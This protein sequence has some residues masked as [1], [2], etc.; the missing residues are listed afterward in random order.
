MA[1]SDFSPAEI[2]QFK[3][4]FDSFDL[5][6]SGTIEK[7]ELKTVMTKLEM[8]VSDHEFDSFFEDAAT[9]GS[10]TFDGFLALIAKIRQGAGDSATK[11]FEQTYKKAQNLLRV[12]GASGTH[13]FSEEEVIAFGDHINA[14]FPNDADLA[15][16]LP[17]DTSGQDL[18][19]KVHD[20]ILL[21]KMINKA[22]KGTIDERALNKRKGD[23]ALSPFQITE[24][25]NLVIQSAKAI[26][27]NVINIGWADLAEGKQHL[28]LGL[29]W[30]IVKIEILSNINIK[31]HPELCRLLEDG[32]ELSDLLRMSPEQILL[33]WFNFHLKAA[34]H[35]R[36]VKNF[37]GDIKDSECYTVLLH[38]L[39]ADQCDMGPMS[40]SDPN[41]RAEAMLANAHKI[42]CRKFVRPQDV[43]RGNPKLNLAFVA[44]IFN[45]RPGLEPPTEEE[46]EKAGLMDDDV[47]DSREERAFR[48]WINSLGIQTYCNNLYEDVRDGV[49][50]LEV[51]D[52]ISPGIVYWKKVNREP[53]SVYKKV[54]NCNYAVVLGK[55]L[56]FS[57]V[58]IG[59]KDI[60]DGNKKLTLALIWQMMRMHLLQYL[61]SLKVE[62]RE[63]TEADMIKWANNRVKAAGKSSQMQ[64]FKD[65]TLKT[66]VFFID[67]LATIEPRIVDWDLVTAGETE[68]D[69]EMNSKYAISIARK[70][71]ATIFCLWE[72]ICEVKPKMMLTV[73]ASIMTVAHTYKPEGQAS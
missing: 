54:E 41:K 22:C 35:E 42:E 52:Y 34:G 12:E 65:A 56:K 40:Q 58:G 38:Q 63:V 62:G 28:V 14:S 2:A 11:L 21:A 24:N 30:Q 49:L 60:V 1:Q 36:R 57:L 13:S 16:L 55:D 7:T 4:E 72:D 46:M 61:Q 15:Y 68:E 39:A 43:V 5:D 53:K 26:G 37:S 59:G 8:K 73:V 45:T 67:L 29:I 31:N 17:I 66:G 20:G 6:K 47:G 9:G 70:L 33:R 69:R 71:G 3:K 18:F 44:N 51:L 64:S 32:E 23:K 25:H 50:L 19:Q 48:M 27:C 10:I